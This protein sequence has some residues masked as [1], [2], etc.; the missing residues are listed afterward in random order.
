MYTRRDDTGRID[1]EYDAPTPSRDAAGVTYTDTASFAAV[2]LRDPPA[3]ASELWRALVDPWDGAGL[4]R[5][6]VVAVRQLV[7]GETRPDARTILRETVGEDALDGALADVLLSL[8]TDTSGDRFWDA[9]A[10][11]PSLGSGRPL[12]FRSDLEDARA[13]ARVLEAVDVTP[14]VAIAL[15]DG[16]RDRD[17]STRSAWC[18]LVAALG[19]GADVRLVCSRV[20]RAWLAEYHRDDLPGVSDARSSRRDAAP[21]ADARDAV[22]V[23]SR[24]ERVLTTVADTD[25]ET[26]AYTR[27]YAAFSV[28]RSRVRQVLADLADA[29]L[30]ERYGS[31]G[32]RRVELT[33]TGRQFVTEE[34]ARQRR[35]SDRV[36]ESGKFYNNRRVTPRTHGEGEDHEDTAPPD[37]PDRHR[38]PTPHERRY[39]DRSTAAAALGSAVEGGV[40]L[41]NY[42]IDAQKD[43]AEGRWYTEDGRLVVSAEGDNPLSLWVTLALTLASPRTFD[44]VLTRSTLDEHG[45]LSM[46]EDARTIPRDMRQIGWLGEDVT[47]YDDLRRAFLDAA[48]DL[49]DRTGDLDDVDDDEE[50]ALRTEILKKALGLAG[51]M[52][53]LL[54]LA[55]VDLVRLVRLPEFSRRFDADGDRAAALWKTIAIGSTIGSRYGHHAAYRQL[56]EDR[57][58]KRRQAFEPTVDAADP[59]ARP[60]GSWVLAGDFRGRT[61]AVADGLR[62]AFD[63]FDPHED[64]PE[65]QVRTTVRTDPTRRQVT[66]TARRIL[67]AKDLR[68]TPEAVSVL[69]GL[70]RTPLDVA[71]ALHA[72]A[73]ENDGRRIDAAEVRYALGTVDPGRLLRGF[74]GRKTTPRRLISALLRAD[75][76]IRGDELDERADV[77]TRSRRE[78]LADLVVLELVE[79]TDAGYRLCLSF[80]DTDGDDGERYTDRWPTWVADP[81]VSPSIHA[82]A[83]ALRVGREHHG[84]GDAVTLPGWPYT[85]VTD[86]PDLR[87]LS[88]P[89][90]WLD[91][92]LPALW[93]VATATEY[94]DDPG[95]VPPSTTRT[96]TAGPTLEQVP[97]DAA[98]DTRGGAAP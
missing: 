45:V 71:D 52:T 64:A 18:R 80:G 87:D 62:D 11:L 85:G 75:A 50:L 93:G 73:G 68:V 96:V 5:P 39:M 55:D 89:W 47:D 77:S 90:P 35:L 24:A 82:A 40:N 61:D 79:E 32:E 76:P 53:H 16:F 44:Q 28:G 2:D 1:D 26:V 42:P 59:V 65:I 69:H 10:R 31:D 17:R 12:G 46:L 36:S 81:T 37:R 6:L 15:P 91:A 78:H 9:L 95:V 84:P 58:G 54:D 48:A 29:G 21:L 27:L 51:S 3:T 4:S 41:L 92:V 98:T 74:D 49:E 13:A 67:D 43:R 25:T 22:G 30:V 56:F 7:A 8:A 19:R 83:K 86:P 34:I 70:A 38:L 60:V 88:T 57:E 97:V 33:A 94:A 20:D 66:E 63:G 14:T 23:G 72:L